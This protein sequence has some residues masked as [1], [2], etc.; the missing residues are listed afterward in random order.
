M[1]FRLL[2]PR[3]RGWILPAIAC[4]VW[5]PDVHAVAAVDE[6]GSP[7]DVLESKGIKVYTSE[8]GLASESKL[9]GRFRD[10]AK[11]RKSLDDAA[12]TVARIEKQVAENKQLLTAYRKK[13]I[14]YTQQ[15]QRTTNLSAKAQL[16]AAL[17]ELSDR[18][19]LLI[20][21]GGMEKEL[22]AARDA[23]HKTRQEYVQ[24]V[25]DVGQDLE[26]VREEY[27]KLALDAEA[28]AAVKALNQETGREYELAESRAFESHERNY[29]R[30]AD[31]VL[32]ES[33]ELRAG[34]G[35]TLFVTAILND[36]H[37]TE[38]AFDSGSSILALPWKTAA[39]I[40][41]TP[42]ANDPEITLRLGD[43][44]TE[45]KARLVLLDSVRVGKFEVENVEC[46]VLPESLTEGSAVLGMT[47]L[48]H[49]IFRVN[50]ETKTLE[51][52]KVEAGR[53][54]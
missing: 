16:V 26:R 43:G 38:M 12:E 34:P 23:E 29:Q 11:L 8:L 45:I 47:F 51:L 6:A 54:R 37:A 53:R 15:L 52:T 28:L 1:P 27:A 14:Q 41:A 4:A 39:E 32:S 36:K 30:L 2:S 33:L 9:S 21:N 44:Q 40:G 24:F 22:A 17:S 31:T 18:M 35:N 20:E 49:F 25:L 46:A 5:L 10:A 42:E 48:R 3:F 50:P 7:R 19:G 13:R